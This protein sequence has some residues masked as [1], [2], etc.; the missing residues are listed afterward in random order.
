MGRGMDKRA[1]CPFF[2]EEPGCGKL[3][4]K[5]KAAH[6]RLCGRRIRCEGLTAKGKIYI[7]FPT[8]EER[9]EHTESFCYSRCWQGCPM[10]QMLNEQY[11]E[12]EL[13]K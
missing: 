4:P 7:E 11:E 6:R 10:A 9:R 1:M 8:E 12:G 5:L 2:I 3:T 13:E